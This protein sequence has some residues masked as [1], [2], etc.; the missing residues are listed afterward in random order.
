VARVSRGKAVGV[1]PLNSVVRPHMGHFVK[2]LAAA[3]VVV[4][5]TPG[6]SLACSCAP[7]E[8]LIENPQ[9]FAKFYDRPELVVVHARVTEVVREGHAKIVT[10]ES[11][12]GPKDVSGIGFVTIGPCGTQLRVGEERVF[13]VYGG[14]INHCSKFEP[15]PAFIALLRTRK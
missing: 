4:A 6:V 7:A 12:R 3:A 5:A 15:A 11:F 1:R 14:W 9:L 13:F 8:A 2:V 10:L